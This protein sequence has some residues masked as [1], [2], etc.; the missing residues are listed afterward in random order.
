MVNVSSGP[1]VFKIM[2]VMEEP[3]HLKNFKKFTKSIAV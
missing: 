3:N 1:L 2:L